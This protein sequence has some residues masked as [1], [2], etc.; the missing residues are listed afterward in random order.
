MACEWYGV[1]RHG[2]CSSLCHQ[3]EP[4]YELRVDVLK[5]IGGLDTRKAGGRGLRF[6]ARIDDNVKCFHDSASGSWC[7]C[8]VAC[9]CAL[10][11][12]GIVLFSHFIYMIKADI[13]VKLQ[14]VNTEEQPDEKYTATCPI[15]L[16]ADALKTREIARLPII[17]KDLSLEELALPA[18]YT[19]IGAMFENPAFV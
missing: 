14:G 15:I 19:R 1:G 2:F 8:S 18:I 5:W 9:E 4:S 17:M 10:F 12:W 7:W 16:Y 11:S 3:Y 6:S 13:Y